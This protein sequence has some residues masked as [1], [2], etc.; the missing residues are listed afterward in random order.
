MTAGVLALLLVARIAAAADPEPSNVFDFG[1]VERGALVEHAF[2]LPNR[3]QN[4]VRIEHVKST[5]GCTVGVASARDIP[6]GGV[7]RVLVTLDT[8]RL[9]G[10]T[11][12]VVSVYTNDPGAPV[13]P[14]TLTGQVMVDLVLAP[15]RL[16]LGRVRRGERVRREVVIAPGRPGTH[17]ALVGVERATSTLRATLAPPDGSVEQRLIVELDAD[18]PLGRFNDHLVL[19]T[20]SPRDPLLTL[21]VFGSIEGDVL[22]LPP[23]VTFGVTR[24][25]AA[26]ERELFIRNR[27]PRPFSV[28]R[29]AVPS[30]LVT[31]ELT[32]VEAGVEYRVTLRLRDQL[33]PGKVEG[34]VEIFTDHPDERRLVVPLYAI[35]RGGR[36]RG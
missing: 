26:A 12:K 13:V 16:Y 2:T 7:G 35:V 6:P 3:G 5:C 15:D 11:T 18:L 33:P 19:R 32:A 28:T 1:T 25:D 14:L 10:R 27:G 24:R 4:E 34:E 17:F 30:E 31:Y 21:P 8:A 9:A 23:H 29:V 20:T 22:V 36:R